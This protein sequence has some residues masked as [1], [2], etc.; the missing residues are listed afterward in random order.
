MEQSSVQACLVC[1]PACLICS[2]PSEAECLSCPPH[3]HLVGTSCL[4]QNQVQRKSPISPVLHSEIVEETDPEMPKMEAS[5][6]LPVLVAV[7][8]CAFILATFAA[9]FVLL[10]L[11]SGAA[12][13]TFCRRTKLQVT[14]SSGRGMRVGFG[15]GFGLG[16]DLTNSRVLYRGIPTVWGD[17][18]TAGGVNSESENEELDC[19]SE[20]RAFI[21]TQSGL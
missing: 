1:H 10:Q 5:S 3:S 14:D 9:V 19:H 13:T 15:F 18:D 21:E 20:N 4:H 11:H 12:S 7:L 16:R 8:S 2:G 6:H 17:E